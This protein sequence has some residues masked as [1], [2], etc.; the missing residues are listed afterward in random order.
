MSRNVPVEIATIVS[1]R[2]DGTALLEVRPRS[3]CADGS[4]CGCGSC[5]GG[6]PARMVAA[7]PDGLP[8]GTLVRVE[9]PNPPLLAVLAV[10]L[11]PLLL[12]L[13]VMTWAARR[14]S[15]PWAALAGLAAMAAWFLLLL[16]LPPARRPRCRILGPAGKPERFDFGERGP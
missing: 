12:F 3:S 10:F 13:S 15:E 11:V 5:G 14:L 2:P 16:L 4:G 8:E 7:N 1:N 6:R 9:V